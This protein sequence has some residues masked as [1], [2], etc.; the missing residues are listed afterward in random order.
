MITKYISELIETVELLVSIIKS[1]S[2][3]QELIE[4]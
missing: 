1:E 3:L 2:L 4:F